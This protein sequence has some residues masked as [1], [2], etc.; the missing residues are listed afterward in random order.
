VKTVRRVRREGKNK[1]RNNKSSRGLIITHS[2]VNIEREKRESE[3]VKGVPSKHL[4]FREY[5]FQ[6]YKLFFFS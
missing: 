6:P 1:R 4:I 2:L 5:Y 3:K